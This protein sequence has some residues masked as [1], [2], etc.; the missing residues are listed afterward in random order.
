MLAFPCKFALLSLVV[1]I[2]FAALPEKARAEAT[3]TVTISTQASRGPI[4]ET[5]K[6][7]PGVTLPPALANLPKTGGPSHRFRVL[8]TSSEPAPA[9]ATA[10]LTVPTGLGMTGPLPLLIS[11][12][13]E[14]PIMRTLPIQLFWGVGSTLP[15][16]QPEVDDLSGLV[17]GTYQHTGH[18]PA[19]YSD[20]AAIGVWPSFQTPPLVVTTDMPTPVG[21]YAL[22]TSFAGSVRFH[23]PPAEAYLDVLRLTTPSGGI[24][25]GQPF[26]IGWTKVARALGYRVVI[27]GRRPDPAAKRPNFILWASSSQKPADVTHDPVFDNPGQAVKEGLLLG[28]DTTGVSVPPGVLDGID[29]AH[30]VIQAFGPVQSQP[31]VAGMPGVRIL[32]VSEAQTT[33]ALPVVP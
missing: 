21:D 7:A 19:D 22:T 32:T 29:G 24:V 33:L 25:A 10:S 6:L 30:V 23:T 9:G 31:A 4:A 28:P 16:G 20:A 11:A 2:W 27:T 5:V 12:P 26:H 17:A 3:L 8:L 15:T 18:P 14:R 13:H 1:L